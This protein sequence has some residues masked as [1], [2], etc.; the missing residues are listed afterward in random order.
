VAVDDP[1]VSDSEI[2]YQ[3]ALI[4]SGS[5]AIPTTAEE[6]ARGASDTLYRTALMK[7]LGYEEMTFSLDDYNEAISRLPQWA[8]LT[9]PAQDAVGA[10][11]DDVETARDLQNKQTVMGGFSESLGE[12]FRAVDRA[13]GNFTPLQIDN[14]VARTAND[15]LPSPAINFVAHTTARG[16]EDGS[17][18]TYYDSNQNVGIAASILAGIGFKYANA[19][20]GAEAG[21]AGTTEV[22]GWDFGPGNIDDSG[23]NF[24]PGNYGDPDVIAQGPNAWDFGPGNMDDSGWNYGPG[25]DNPTPIQNPPTL[26]DKLID[27]AGAAALKGLESL[28]K[29]S[30]DT[31]ADTGAAAGTAPKK[32]SAGLLALL[33][34]AAAIVAVN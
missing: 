34:I 32:S 15:I 10:Y 7:K 31:A 14:A 22:S 2:Q 20:A 16:P 26:L 1:W 9:A 27:K 18:N 23:W 29:P 13:G 33:G 21:A 28:L 3:K 24:G 19:P 8:A 12:M 25:S 4:L 6:F 5:L 30:Q 11:L 17:D